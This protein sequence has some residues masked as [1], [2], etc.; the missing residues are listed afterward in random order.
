[1]TDSSV[2]NPDL[3]VFS[4][5]L[6]GM[7]SDCYFVFLRGI[8]VGGNKKVPMTELKRLL[9][10]NG[11][12]GVETLLNSGNI[13]LYSNESNSEQIEK[14]LE[15]LLETHFGFSIPVIVRK[16]EEIQTLYAQA[17]FKEISITKNT[18]LYI[19]MLQ[20]D[21]TSEL[22][23]PWVSEDGSYSILKKNGKDIISVL[24]LGTTKSTDAMKILEQQYGKAITTRN[25][26]TIEKMI[27]KL[28]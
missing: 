26:N 27:Q 22:Q 2:P 1:M 10:R 13:V 28:P 6:Y 12:N 11:Y 23:L 15:P 5:F 19:S 3:Y 25:W 21:V 16:A 8:N 9:E 20:T 7:K 4:L 18:R 24:E 17:P 14:A